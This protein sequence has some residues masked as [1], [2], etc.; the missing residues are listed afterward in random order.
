VVES[1]PLSSVEPELEP[2]LDP[3]LDEP[4]S[5]VTELSGGGA[6]ESVP[7]LLPSA[8]ASSPPELE[9]LD[10]EPPSAVEELSSDGPPSVEG[11]SPRPPMSRPHD[12]R[13]TVVTATVERDAS[14]RM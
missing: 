8:V 2:L 1:P 5:A 6:V 13:M 11:P 4:P 12:A 14:T 3:P 7:L 10:E 9:P